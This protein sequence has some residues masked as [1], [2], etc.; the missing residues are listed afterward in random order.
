MSKSNEKKRDFFWLS[1]SDLMTSL[2]FVMLVLFV[3]VYTMQAK[4]IGELTAAKIE[5]DEI[6]KIQE[7][8]KN[9]D[10]RYFVFDTRNKRYKLKVDVNFKGNS[11][12]IHDIP[13][14]LQNDLLLA[15]K[16][17]FDLMTKLT[18][19]NPNVNYLVIVEGNT[20]RTQGNF[21]T[22]PDVG[23]VLSYNRSLS[24]VNL[25]QQNGLNFK[26]FKNC[27]I[28][29]TGSGYFGKSREL[30]EAENRKFTI[31]ITPK[32]GNIIKK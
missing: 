4:M 27:E 9:L 17:I 25:W 14:A 6:H 13:T 10:K 32:I 30:N 5:L 3:L 15:G 21:I 26:S 19:E 1:Y 12:N 22:M 28:L 23:Y 2:F 16:N 8:L 20:Q 11:S 18:K 7:A 24:L 29:I 31:Q